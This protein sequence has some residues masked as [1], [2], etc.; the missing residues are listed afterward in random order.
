MPWA[1]DRRGT[2]DQGEELIGEEL[3]L[4]VMFFQV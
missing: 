3:S 4:W 2:A 1:K